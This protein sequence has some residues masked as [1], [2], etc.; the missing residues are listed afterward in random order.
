[1]AALIKTVREAMN[2]F[3][4]IRAFDLDDSR[5]PT[6]EEVEAIRKAFIG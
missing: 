6:K 5:V 1:M 2:I 4:L 3:D